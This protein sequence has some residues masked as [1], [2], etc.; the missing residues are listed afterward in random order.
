M[1]S[2]SVL[3]T[4]W[5]TGHQAELAALPF[6]GR[7]DLVLT[8][9]SWAKVQRPFPENAR[10][11]IEVPK[12]HDYDLAI[13]H[14]DQQVIEP[15][16]SKGLIFHDLFTIAK[17]R[18]I[19]TVVINHMTPF[20]DRVDTKTVIEKVKRL[21]GDTQMVVNSKTAAG[22]WGFGR[23]I[24]H[25]MRIDQWENN[26]KEPRIVTILSGGGMEKAYRRRLLTETMSILKED[27][28]EKIIWIGGGAPRRESFAEYRE[29]LA[30]SLI[31]FNP[32]WQ[33][34]M[35]RSRTEAML[36]GACIVSTKHQDWEDYIKQG[37]NGFVV[38]DK[39]KTVALLLNELVKD[40]ETA[41]KVGQE[42]RKTARKIFN[43][44]NFIQ[45]WEDLLTEMGIL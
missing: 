21:L 13:L 34:P 39:P 19:P 40:Y 8:S 38:E 10:Y 5:H 33:S 29:F 22:Q 45:Q 18:Q 1:K 32:T 43:Q 15:R 9:K 16:I 24:I 7:Y 37:V 26:A 35:P 17:D 31:Y 42:G 4:S 11:I 36:S 27:Y 25:G 41:Y 20:S 2:L 23:P 44:K 3:G 6:I 28:G 14:I 12:E 30:R